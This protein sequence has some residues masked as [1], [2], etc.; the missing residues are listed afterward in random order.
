MEAPS[1]EELQSLNYAELRKLAKKNGYKAN[2]KAYELLKTLKKHFHPTAKTEQSND[3]TSNDKDAQ[4]SAKP[5]SA[6]RQRK[7]PRTEIPAKTLA[8]TEITT[9]SQSRKIPRYTS[10]LSKSGSKASTPNFKKLHEAQFKKMESID[11]FMER[12][13]KHTDA[14]SS[15]R[16][17]VKKSLHSRFSQR[18]TTPQKSDLTPAKTPRRQKH[19]SATS[20]R[21]LVDNSGFK[22]KACSSSKRN[23]RFS[24][25]TKDNEHKRSLIKTPARKYS[26]FLPFSPSKNVE[27]CLPTSSKSIRETNA[28]ANNQSVTTPFKFTAQTL[29]TP[30]TNKKP[31]FDLQASLKRPLAYMPYTGKLKPFGEAKENQEDFKNKSSMLKKT[32]KQPPLPTRDDRRKE[33]ERER[34]CKRDK[35]VATCRGIA[36]P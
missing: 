28:E 21:I 30:N 24:E 34:K 18:S 32:Y 16:Q 19:S 7:R 1:V 17:E 9:K 14:V 22:P 8:T 29:E 35:I 5:R 13:K 10:Q 11:I 15:T 2:L 27:R 12:R 36:I 20:S 4:E 6:K 26:P 25:T 31:K 3:E 33:H 23:V